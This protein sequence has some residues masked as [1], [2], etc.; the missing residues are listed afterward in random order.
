M[1]CNK[2]R[3]D[4]TISRSD[5]TKSCSGQDNMPQNLVP[6]K[7]QQNLVPDNKILF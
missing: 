3:S 1:I 2:P 7:M 5:A 4:A 6:I